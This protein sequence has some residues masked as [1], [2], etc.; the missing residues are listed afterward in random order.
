MIVC[1]LASLPNVGHRRGDPVAALEGRPSPAKEIRARAPMGFRYRA[2]TSQTTKQIIT[3]V[4]IKPYPN[5]VAS[6]YPILT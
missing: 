5:I 2:R 4:P 6:I 1:V 3:R